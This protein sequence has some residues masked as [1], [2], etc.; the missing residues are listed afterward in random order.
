MPSSLRPPREGIWSLRALMKSARPLL[1]KAAASRA[2][3]PFRGGE[4]W[5]DRSCHPLD[6]PSPRAAGFF[7]RVASIASLSWPRVCPRKRR[8][9]PS[10]WRL[11]SP[12]VRDPR[13]PPRG[14]AGDA[15]P[16]PHGPHDPC[17]LVRHCRAGPPS[18]REPP[19]SPVAAT[20]RAQLT[21]APRRPCPVAQ[22]WAQGAI[23]PRADPS[24]SRRPT[25]GVLLGHHPSPGGTRAAIREHPAMASRRD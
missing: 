2:V 4:R 17:R 24:P 3:S 12:L 18:T 13:G 25:R 21:P 7:T 6:H 19:P 1:N 15:T 14:G 9:H 10:C 11:V 8:G 22:P 16:P 5:S 20:V 23:A